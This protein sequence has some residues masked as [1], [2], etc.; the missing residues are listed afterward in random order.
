MSQLHLGPKISQVHCG[1]QPFHPFVG[2]LGHFEGG[3]PEAI[4]HGDVQA[5]FPS[6]WPDSLL[7]PALDFFVRALISTQLNPGP[8]FQAT[9]QCSPSPKP[10]QP[11][12][13]G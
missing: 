5:A 11:H 1:K 2:P 6:L 13:H 3:L 8:R 4:T 9:E 12:R 10:R 7:G